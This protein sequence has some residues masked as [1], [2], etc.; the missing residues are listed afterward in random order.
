MDCY[1]LREEYFQWLGRFVG[2]YDHRCI[3]KA[4]HS[5]EFSYVVP[6]DGNRYED[7]VN[8]RYRFAD[9]HGY[10]YKY[11]TAWLD[12]RPCTVLEMMVALAVRIE[13]QIATDPDHGNRTAR[14][15]EDMLKS[16]DIWEFDDRHYDDTAVREAIDRM[17][18]RRYDRNGRGGLFW[19]RKPRRDMRH[20]EIW[21]QAMWYL[22]EIL[23]IR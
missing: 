17:I 2:C 21:Y 19:L 9:E 14:W 5:V 18:D 8:L 7:G 15:F 12:D 11:I 6:M 10:P 22:D 3:L 4:L 20:A 1:E 16:M 23:N 13:D